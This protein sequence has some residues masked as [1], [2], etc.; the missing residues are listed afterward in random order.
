MDRT[1]EQ[2]AV[3]EKKDYIDIMAFLRAFIRYVRRYLA[4]ALALTIFMTVC[5]S[6]GMAA[7]SKKLK[8]S[9]YIASG[10]FTVGVLVS[11][12]LSYNYVLSGLGSRYAILNKATNAI[13]GLMDSYY[14]KQ[15]IRK[16]LGL[17]PDDELNGT[18]S[19]EVTS[20]TNLIDIRVTSDSEEDAEAIRDAVLACFKDAIFPVLGYIELNIVNLDTEEIPSSKAFL[21]NPVIWVILGVFLGT[22]MY[23]GILF[24]YALFWKNLETPE[25]ISEIIAIPC[26]ARIP[27]QKKKKGEYKKYFV[28][29]R[30]RISEEVKKKDIKVL[31]LTGINSKKAMSAIA[32]ELESDFREQGMKIAVTNFDEKVES[33]TEESVRKTLDE[34]LKKAELV[35][36]DGAL[37]GT[38]AAPLILADC[39]DA[40]IYMIEQGNAPPQKVKD[41]HKSLQ[42]SRAKAIGYVL[43]NCNYMK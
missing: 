34:L 23:L 36:I 24:V 6:G 17:E 5:V 37:C 28:S 14:M 15:R 18:I 10:S 38:S 26:L 42:F 27:V 20:Q 31:L 11:D 43:H 41:M 2:K 4:F 9:T 7:V 32:R 13:V 19:T 12:S 29:M 8:K 39:S 21:A 25:D 1:D 3:V 16:E 40:V 30:R 22:F 35:L 33:V